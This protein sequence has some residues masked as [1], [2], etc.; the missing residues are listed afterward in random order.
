MLQIG[1]KLTPQQ[2]L[3][4][5]VVDIMGS[6][7]YV[8]LAGILMIGNRSI[9]DGIPTAYTDGKNEKYGTEFVEGLNDAELRFLVLHENY[10]KLY[11]HLDTWK[12]LVQENHELAN[13]AMDM[14]IN[15]KLVTDNHEDKFATMT[16][17]LEIGCYDV[18][19]EGW[20]TARVYHDLKKNGMP[21]PQGGTPGQGGASQGNGSSQGFDV[22]DHENAQAMSDSDK[23]ELAREIDEA[24]R[25]GAMVAGKTG[26]GGD[27]DFDELLKPKVD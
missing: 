27:R 19:Y 14:V 3:S 25:Q 8:A 22:H 15:T 5:A 13:V 26:S 17:G 16:G 6:P 1:K 11:R 18:K 9:E 21:K 10:H 12:H 20:D 4:K 2:R 24:I 7:K 23:K